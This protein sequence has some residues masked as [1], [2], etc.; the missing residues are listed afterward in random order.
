VELSEVNPIFVG[1]KLDS[2]LRRQLES[3]SGPDSKYVSRENSTFLLLCRRGEDLFVGK[4]IEK[5][6]T[7]DSVD[8]VRRNILSIMQRLCPDVRLP[9]KMDILACHPPMLQEEKKPSI[10]G[11]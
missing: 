1:F 5:G 7:T 4:V 8:D 11:F 10:E 9:D 2:S 3:L 6:F